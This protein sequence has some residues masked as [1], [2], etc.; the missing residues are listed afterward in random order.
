MGLIQQKKKPS[1]EGKDRNSLPPCLCTPEAPFPIR[2]LPLP[3]AVRDPASA[4]GLPAS[5]LRP[6]PDSGGRAPPLQALAAQ[7]KLY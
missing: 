1:N 3:T 4:S 7:G 6:A 5:G 2:S